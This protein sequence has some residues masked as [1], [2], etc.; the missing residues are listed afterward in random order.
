MMPFHVQHCPGLSA[1]GPIKKGNEIAEAGL[2]SPLS[3]CWF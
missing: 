2:L 1:L 3:M